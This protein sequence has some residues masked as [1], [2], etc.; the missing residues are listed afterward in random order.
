MVCFIGSYVNVL[1]WS[2]LDRSPL[3]KETMA[4]NGHTQEDKGVGVDDVPP[5]RLLCGV[6]Q[7]LLQ[8]CLLL[9]TQLGTLLLLQAAEAHQSFLTKA[10]LL[11][12]FCNHRDNV[13]HSNMRVTLS[14]DEDE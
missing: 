5:Q 1:H 13:K 12:W 4:E 7:L 3:T 14:P 6:R 11:S 9:C 10:G 2:C 8:L